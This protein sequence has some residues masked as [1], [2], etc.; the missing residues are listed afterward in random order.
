[1]SFGETLRSRRGEQ[2]TDREARR[3]GEA[4]AGELRTAHGT[5][6][7]WELAANEGVTIRRSE[8]SGVDRLRLFGTYADGVI[9]LYDAQIPVLAER[10]GVSESLAT[11][12]VLAHELGHHVLDVSAVERTPRSPLREALSSWFGGSADERELEERAAQWFAVELLG[13]RLPDT[14]RRKL[15]RGVG[16]IE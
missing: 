7:V 14:A 6:N 2:S 1:M 16:D 4:K 5:D 15:R 9:T 13:D 8:W 11:E 3:F 12:L 10:L